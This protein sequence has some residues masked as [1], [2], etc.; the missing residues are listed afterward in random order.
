MIK[1]L[2]IHWRFFLLAIMF[3]CSI[4]T[5]CGDEL[6]ASAQQ[7]LKDQGFYYGDVDG[8]N[9]PETTAAI[10]RYQIRYGLKINGELNTETRRSLGVS[11]EQPSRSVVKKEVPTPLDDQPV[12][13]DTTARERT[14]SPP[15]PLPNRGYPPGMQPQTNGV[16]DGTPYEGAPPDIQRQIIA[17]AQTML[18]R[19]GYYRSDI[20]GVY[21]PG[22]E[23][24]V[25]A[26]QARVGLVVSGRF[27]VETLAALGMLPGAHWLGQSHPRSLRPRSERIYKGE[28]VPQ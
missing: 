28:W 4:S 21:G 23:F 8:R 17:H 7:I 16:L 26:Y 3:L 22:T 27:D 18:A 9:S 20:D 15:R 12:S 14:I 13:P 19:R 10:R 25:R 2:T 24:A 5:V 11:A 6:I 1:P